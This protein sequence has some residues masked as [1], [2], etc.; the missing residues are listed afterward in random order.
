MVQHRFYNTFPFEILQ[1]KSNHAS[2][3]LKK[4]FGVCLCM[5]ISS[6][7]GDYKPNAVLVHN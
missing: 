1:H 7:N 5:V 3:L 4:V 2:V 6:Y